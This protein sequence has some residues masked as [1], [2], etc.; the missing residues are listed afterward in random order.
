MLA[1]C[2]GGGSG[3]AGN[4]PSSPP[5][6][7]GFNRGPVLERPYRD[8]R[9]VQFHP[10]RY[11][12]TE[13]LTM[14]SDPE[15][16][17]LTY[18]IVYGHSFNPREDPSPPPGFHIEGTSIVGAPQ[19]LDTVGV[20]VTVRDTAGNVS[21]A[22]FMI[23]VTPNTAPQVVN[24]NHDHVVTVGAR[25]DYEVTG[26]GTVFTDAD[27]DELTYEVTTRTDPRGL[28]VAGTTVSGTFDSVGLV[29]VTVT[30]SDAYGGSDSDV[31][32]VA[33]PGPEPG[34]PVL[35]AV[36]YSYADEE[37]ALPFIFRMSSEG[38]TPLWDTQ[39]PDNRTGNAG[40]ALG[41]VLFY[42]KRLSSTNTVSCSSCHLQSHGFASPKQFDSGA[43][44]IPLK[45]NTM[46]L[47]NARYSIHRSWFSDMRVHRIRD[48][49]LIPIQ[50]PEELG[51][52]L[53]AL[54]AKLA[55]TDFYPPLF[56]AAFGSPEVTTERIALALE[57]FVQALI[58]YRAKVD[59]AVNPMT[60]DPWDP[61]SALD[62]QELR[63]FEIFTGPGTT[64]SICHEIHA[65][66]NEWQ[67]NNG[68]DVV[69]TDPGVQDIGL[70][71]TGAKGVFKAASLR[72][73]ALSAPYMHDGRFAT[74]R[75][76]IDHYDHGVQ[77]SP[78]LDFILIAGEPE[79]RRM[80][81]SEE[82]K[83]ALEAFLR[84]FTD[85]AFVGDPKFSDP[86]PP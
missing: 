24:P 25:V 47:A 48:L 76:V 4:P 6:Q 49:V 78:D 53:D 19:T 67:A 18:E 10:F 45:R 9:I 8:Q 68:L 60:N 38:E 64:C 83:N 69:P 57:Q 85:D 27:G 46:A 43:L 54:E 28:G 20:E 74:L 44:G 70:T 81:L 33:A 5:P 7:G 59:L 21:T 34:R 62:A 71:R 72:N 26:N 73:I 2:G 84:T 77:N 50:N 23:F 31:F 35:P 61:A 66:A 41:R 79:P 40:A 80:N 75:E 29:E 56:Q 86:F 30:A 39:L 1:A 58:S 14:F 65:G 3:S 82:D 42:D 22:Q 15:G 12:V 17:A 32:V 52:S 37:L 51:S 55:A 36:A 63:G 11:D 16:D 13:K